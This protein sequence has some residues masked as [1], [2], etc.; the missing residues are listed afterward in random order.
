MSP[1]SA[2]CISFGPAGP[3]TRMRGSNV[4]YKVLS[5][6]VL[7]ALPSGDAANGQTRSLKME[8]IQDKVYERFVE[9]LAGDRQAYDDRLD[10]FEIRFDMALKRLRQDARRQAWRDENRTQT[11]SY[12]DDTG[13]L[14]SEIEKAA[15]SVNLLEGLEIDDEAFRLGLDAAIE[16]LPAEQSRTIQMLMLDYQIHSED[17][18]ALPTLRSQRPELAVFSPSVFMLDG[19]QADIPIRSRGRC[20]PPPNRTSRTLSAIACNTS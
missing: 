6:R 8:R 14:S 16:T 11:I 10:F 3:T 15:G 9:M 12:D 13:E 1:P 17:P 4:L 5:A 7:R 2:C 20:S 19:A 18:N